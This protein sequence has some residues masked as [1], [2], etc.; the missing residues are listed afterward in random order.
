MVDMNICWYSDDE[1]EIYFNK[2]PLLNICFA[3]PWMS[4]IEVDDINNKPFIF[5]MFYLV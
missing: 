3:A 2:E 4:Q 1:I 5:F